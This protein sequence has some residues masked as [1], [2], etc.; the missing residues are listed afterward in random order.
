M[1]PGMKTIGG[2]TSDLLSLS[3]LI[4]NLLIALAFGWGED[5]DEL[6]DLFEY[7][8]RKSAIG[9]GATWTYENFLLLL[10]IMQQSDAEE[11]ARDIKRSISPVIPSEIKHIPAFN[12][13]VDYVADEI[14]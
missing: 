2:S 7:Y 10:H 8:M 3:M 14:N 13:L 12:K 4:P 6:K 1:I 5:E 11:L 9:Y